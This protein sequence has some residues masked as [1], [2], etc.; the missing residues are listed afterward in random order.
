MLAPFFNVVFSVISSK[1]TLLI[2]YCLDYFQLLV[3]HR[4]LIITGSAAAI[5]VSRL[6]FRI[7]LI[8]TASKHPEADTLYVEESEPFSMPLL[9]LFFYC[10]LFQLTLVKALHELF[11]V[12]WYNRFLLSKCRLV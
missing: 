2:C 3:L 8:T 12:D 9:A 10:C 6:D 7:G 5:D 11:V 4:L 1:H